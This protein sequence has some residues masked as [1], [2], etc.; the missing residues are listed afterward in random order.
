M[1]H[2]LVVDEMFPEGP[3]PFMDLEMPGGS[4]RLFVDVSFDDKAV[5]A[6]FFNDFDDLYDD[7]DLE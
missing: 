2:S 5:H 3:G 6:D 7:E 4:N 1:K